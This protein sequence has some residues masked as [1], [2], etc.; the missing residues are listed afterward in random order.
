MLHPSLRGGYSS[1]M[2]ITHVCMQCDISQVIFLQIDHEPQNFPIYDIPLVISNFTF[3]IS[4]VT[5]TAYISAICTGFNT[6]IYGFP[7]I[8]KTSSIV[9]AVCKGVEIVSQLQNILTY[10]RHS[11]PAPIYFVYSPVLI[12]QTFTRFTGQ[13]PA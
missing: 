6:G 9:Y 13:C 11:C 1:R 5:K 4:I 7:Y 8:L 3:V 12:Y 2:I 10:F